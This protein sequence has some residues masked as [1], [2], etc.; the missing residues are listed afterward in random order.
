MEATWLIDGTGWD[1]LL[2]NCATS[3]AILSYSCEEGTVSI[4]TAS[5][6]M[7]IIFNASGQQWQQSANRVPAMIYN[8]EPVSAR[9]LAIIDCTLARRPT[10]VWAGKTTCCQQQEWIDT[11]RV[12]QCIV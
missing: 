1:R 11:G 2:E 7:T 5:N 8:D 9:G 3:T 10:D 6:V 12:N 4:N